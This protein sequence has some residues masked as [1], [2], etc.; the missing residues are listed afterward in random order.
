MTADEKDW[1]SETLTRHARLTIA[2][3]GLMENILNRN[4]I[5]YLNITGRTK[6]LVSADEKI[7]RKKY[8]NPKIQLTQANASFKMRQSEDPRDRLFAELQDR[9]ASIESKITKPRR[10]L[11]SDAKEKDLLRDHTFDRMIAIVQEKR[12]GG[13]SDSDIIGVL[14]NNLTS[15]DEV[16]DSITFDKYRALVVE[17]PGMTYTGPRPDKAN[18]VD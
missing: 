7:R 3:T 4:E 12:S 9:L 6:D 11:V 17:F 5:E 15:F 10:N 1:L 8:A 13:A 18:D 16:P 2:V 14:A